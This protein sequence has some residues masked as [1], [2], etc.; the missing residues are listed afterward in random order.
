MENT[1]GG[2]SMPSARAG[3]VTHQ[4][5]GLVDIKTSRRNVRFTSDADPLAQNAASA[6]VPAA[7]RCA[8]IITVQNS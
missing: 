1:A 5:A 4:P 3:S 2:T 7:V 6:K 8:Q